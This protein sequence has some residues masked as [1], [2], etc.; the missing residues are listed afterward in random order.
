MR[1]TT[2][3]PLVWRGIPATLEVDSYRFGKDPKGHALG[4]DA[5][6]VTTTGAP[7]PMNSWD[8]EAHSIGWSLSDPDWFAE[9]DPVEYALDCLDA[10]AKGNAK[11]EMATVAHELTTRQGD[12]FS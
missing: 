5:F 3:Y 9:Q 4:G 7:L 8:H 1:D 6:K 12:L 11:F 2:E 10:F